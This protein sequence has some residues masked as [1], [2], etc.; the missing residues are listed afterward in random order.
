MAETK[1][2]AGVEDGET[3]AGTVGGEM[4]AARMLDGAGFTGFESHFLFLSGN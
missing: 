4:A 3:A 2:R 1:M